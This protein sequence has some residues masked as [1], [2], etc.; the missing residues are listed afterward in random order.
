M[1][2]RWIT[3]GRLS[4]WV[5]GSVFFVL[6]SLSNGCLAQE[7]SPALAKA[8][9]VPTFE[10]LP[11]TPLPRGEFVAWCGRNDRYLL[12]P[13]NYYVDAYD[14]DTKISAPSATASPSAQCG[15]DGR[16][17]VFTEDNDRRVRK[18][19]L[20]TGKSQILATFE[21]PLIRAIEVSFSPDLKTV[22]TNLPLQLTADAGELRIIQLSKSAGISKVRWAPDGSKVF[23]TYSN[24][25]DV[26]DGKGKRIGGGILPRNAYVR[27][28]W[29]DTEQTSL[30]LFLVTELDE[31]GGPLVRCRIADWQCTRLKGRVEQA[32]G[33]GKGLIGTVGPLDRPKPPDDDSVV[34]YSRYAAELRDASFRLLFRQEFT[35]AAGQ[36]DI[37][38]YVSPSAAKAVLAWS[39]SEHAKCPDPANDKCQPGWILDIA[40]V[41][42]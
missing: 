16:H 6:L 42:K 9:A 8:R 15:A 31:S 14:G 12:A 4:H 20:E 41:V 18:V 7:R 29:F 11:H 5:R 2:S 19:E 38:F 17:I 22:I 33:G 25:V 23:V 36:T 26:F 37:Q 21:K 35:R 39:P 10:T 32:S 40:K 28:G 13:E 27:E 34:L 3:C 1:L 30:L 24:K